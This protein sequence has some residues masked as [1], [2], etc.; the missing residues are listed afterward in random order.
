MDRDTIDQMLIEQDISPDEVILVEEHINETG[1]LILVA[2]L[3]D[4]TE[5]EFYRGIRQIATVH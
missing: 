5:R 2:L 3:T 4:L 1:E